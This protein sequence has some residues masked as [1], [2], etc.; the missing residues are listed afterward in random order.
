ME[1]YAQSRLFDP[2]GFEGQIIFVYPK[3]DLV[4]VM[5]GENPDYV[6]V[7]TRYVGQIVDSIRPEL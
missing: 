4:M 1:A 2:L 3:Y 7:M 5:T 6:E